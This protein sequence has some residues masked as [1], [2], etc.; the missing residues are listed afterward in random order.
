MPSAV[1]PLFTSGQSMPANSV[2]LV[3][4]VPTITGGRGKGTSFFPNHFDFE[5][6]HALG[7]R[8]LRPNQDWLGYEPIDV[9]LAFGERNDPFSIEHDL[10]RGDD[11]VF[12]LDGTE[13]NSTARA[14][15]D[16]EHR[17]Y[18]REPIE[19]TDAWAVYMQQTGR[20]G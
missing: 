17:S 7:I 10:I 13:P 9:V 20:M 11:L 12:V 6:M 2:R 19:Q 5:L 1:S 16:A 14:A 15:H 8:S 18:S 4:D 3:E